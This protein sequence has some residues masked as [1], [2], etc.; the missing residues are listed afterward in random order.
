MKMKRKDEEN[1]KRNF[2][3][4]KMRNEDKEKVQDM[5][6]DMGVTMSTFVRMALK[7]FMKGK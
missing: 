5:A 6:D 2:I 1:N 4:V 3:A 7:E